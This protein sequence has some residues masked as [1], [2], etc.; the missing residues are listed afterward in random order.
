MSEQALDNLRRGHEAFN[1][2][3]LSVMIDLVTSDVDWGSTGVFPGLTDHYRGPHAL[4]SWADVVRSEWEQ[5]DVSLAEVL[6][7]SPEVMVVVERLRGRGRTSGAQVEMSVVAV[8][9]L[10]EQDMI[11]KRSAF[12][13]PAAALEAAG[14]E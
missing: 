1:R 13:E 5:L 12:T 2:G 9:W 8:Y 6:Y 7:D 4:Q 3:D 11:V 10:D 14:V